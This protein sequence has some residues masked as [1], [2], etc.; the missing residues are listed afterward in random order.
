M[1]VGQLLVAVQK[2]PSLYV[3]WLTVAALV[4]LV[5]GLACMLRVALRVLDVD[6]TLPGVATD[7]FRRITKDKS[8]PSEQTLRELVG[9]ATDAYEQNHAYIQARVP[10]TKRF[11]FW[12]HWSLASS[13]AA[14]VLLT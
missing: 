10:N 14:V 11:K 7:A 8:Q 4:A 6:I 5:T 12:S 9:N 1:F 2:F 13:L 3:Q